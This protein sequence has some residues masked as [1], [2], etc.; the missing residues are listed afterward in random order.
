M[1]LV[2]QCALAAGV[3]RARYDVLMAELRRY[4]VEEPDK[5]EPWT[6]FGTLASLE[7]YGSAMLRP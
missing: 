3:Y 2:D 7:E 4:A 5:I 6:T 1:R